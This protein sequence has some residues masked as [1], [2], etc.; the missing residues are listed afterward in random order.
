MGSPFSWFPILPGSADPLVFKEFFSDIACKH[1]P[2]EY[3]ELAGAVLDGVT[4]GGLSEE[5]RDALALVRR[6]GKPVIDTIS[7]RLFLPLF[8]AEKL[9]GVAVLEGGKSSLYEK[10]TIRELLDSSRGITSDFIALQARAIEPL[11]GLFNAVL[12]RENLENSL[13]KR[14]DFVLLL[15]E[16]YPRARDAAHA[17][18]YLKMAAGALNSMVGQDTA[19]FHLGS[20]VFGMLWRGVK[21]GEVRVTADVILYRLQRAGLD[22]AHMGQVWVDGQGV[23]DFA[24]LMDRAWQA[25]VMARQ[26][27]PFAKAAYL[28][29]VERGEHPFRSLTSTELNFFRRL[30][31]NME[32]FWIAALQCDQADS[33][34][35]EIMG[36]HLDPG[37][38]LF[39]REGDG[40]YL[41]FAE[42]DHDS[43]LTALKN[44]QGI[45]AEL[46]GVTFSAGLAGF[47]SAGCKRSVVPLNARKALQHTFF[48]GSASI[49]F[50]DGVSLN[51]SGDVYYND[52]DMNGA[53]REYRL[54]LELA[55]ANV[56]LLN[57]LGVAYVRLN[58][59]KA[60][61]S[62]FEQTLE[63][64]PGNYMA[65]FNLG[66]A[67]LTYGRD[68]LALGFFEKALA[69]DD[70][71]FDLTLQLA[72]L[73]CRCGQYEKVVG[74][75]DVDDEERTRREDWE[76]VS[77]LRCLGEAW[78]NLGENR[79]AMA[80][81][82]QAIVFNPQ[83]SRALSMLGELYDIEGQGD[84]IA[85]S[86]CREA[87]ALDDAK[88]D[89]CHRLGLVLHR[90][91]F[92]P[93]AIATLQVS[94]R[95]NR[96]NA[97]AVA[98]LEEI[99]RKM[100]KVRLAERM[101]AKMEKLTERKQA[102][103]INRQKYL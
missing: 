56:N 61:I 80:C 60:A 14:E 55:P 101:V 33:N 74:L 97:E 48:F 100:G 1:L 84:D 77:A 95:L 35:G 10:Y 34:L 64:E 71:I 54:G 86:L 98:V 42:H 4:E 87:V 69:I 92:T 28:D 72:E 45:V 39:E 70:S 94:L 57:S 44:L 50:F 24:G 82:Q 5:S 22:R 37:V 66:S 17:Q 27:G 58:R 8:F 102:S 12:W 15:L 36:N 2:C 63:V 29:E 78:R 62:C 99:Y 31:L 25:V 75:L 89:N 6:N 79:R 93:E 16:I 40:M 18:A 85:L 38:Y 73:Y 3:A 32:E 81:L 49:T 90:Q 26:R 43:A 21:S 46:S 53:V 30:W 88:W 59:L 103:D 68:D 7:P 9:Y 47:P 19:V 13:A 65:L 51:I 11:T 96:R 83:D 23:L 20:G 91:G 41:F 52:G 76:D 67:W